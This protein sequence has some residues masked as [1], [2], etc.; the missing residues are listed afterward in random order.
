[1]KQVWGQGILKSKVGNGSGRSLLLKTKGQITKY[2][3]INKPINNLL[4]G[5]SQFETASNGNYI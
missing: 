2:Y 4:N 5:Y 1:L 3:P